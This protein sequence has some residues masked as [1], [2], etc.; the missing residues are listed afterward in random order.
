MSHFRQLAAIMF[1]DIA[2][3]TALM[4]EDEEKAFELLRTNRRVQRPVIEKYGGRWIKELGDGVLATFSNAT[5]AVC[6]AGAIH[7][8]CLGTELKLRI[9]INLGEVV[10]ENNDVFG[11]GVNVASRL[12]SVA[13]IGGIFISESVHKNISN[14]KGIETTF[15][16][17]EVLKHVKIPVQIY[18]VNIESVHVEEA[19]LAFANHPP[20]RIIPRKSIAV[21]PFENIG[22]DPEQEYFSDGMAEEILNVLSNLKG[23]KVVGRSSSFQFKGQNVNLPDIGSKLGVYSVLEGSVRRQGDKL[24]ITVRLT[25]VEDG[26]QLWAEKYDR[27]MIDVFEIQDEIAEKIAE[28]LKVTF[29]EELENK[30]DRIPTQN[31]QAYELV[32]RGR[33]FLDKYIEGF[34]KA[35]ECF[36]KAIELD[37]DYAEAYSELAR[38]HFLFAMFLFCNSREGFERAKGYAQK[39]LSL[40]NDLGGAHYVLGQIYFWY[41]WDWQRAKKEYEAA[42]HSSISYYFTGIVLDPWYPA[43]L[44]GNFDAAIQSMHK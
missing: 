21:L 2:G 10:F 43:L 19:T 24:R 40:N 25:N 13:P 38:L 6:C 12:Q 31:M 1:T 14:K 37:P 36:N 8:C 34:E 3:Y 9:G 23:L 35:L 16:R 5:D 4:G 15:V 28:K 11:D 44:Y 39:A 32:L 29:F 41:N 27:Q 7:K 42:E 26:Y 22:N 30:T 18:E 17:E 20:E 33:F